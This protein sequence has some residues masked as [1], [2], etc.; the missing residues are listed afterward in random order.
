MRH[1]ESLPTIG[2]SCNTTTTRLHNS[3][4]PP[5]IPPTNGVPGFSHDGLVQ[6]PLPSSSLGQPLLI[7][8][9]TP[10]ASSPTL[11]RVPTI[12]G[13]PTFENCIAAAR[14]IIADSANWTEGK[15]FN[16]GTCR[17]FSKKISS[18][19]NWYMRLSRHGPEDGTFSDFWAVLGSHHSENEAQ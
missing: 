8:S 9:P 19:P 4:P 11:H 13:I 14:Q 12:T 5:P 16:N 2:P 1:R 17:T 10:P 15:T 6:C 18:G 3:S 7:V